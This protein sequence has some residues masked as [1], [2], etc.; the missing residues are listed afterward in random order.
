[1]FISSRLFL[2]FAS[3]L[4]GRALSGDGHSALARLRLGSQSDAETI[5]MY[6]TGYRATRGWPL[7]PAR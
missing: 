6:L 7:R 4:R 5:L 1:M 2:G 3:G